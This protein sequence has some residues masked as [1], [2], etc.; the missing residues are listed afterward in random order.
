MNEDV[1]ITI[2]LR[3]DNKAAFLFENFIYKIKKID[4]EIKF[5][6]QPAAYVINNIV[7]SF[8]TREQIGNK[9]VDCI[10]DLDGYKFFD[11]DKNCRCKLCSKPIVP[12]FPSV[13]TGVKN[14]SVTIAQWTEK[15]FFDLI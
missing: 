6:E 4:K 11:I 10:K 15:E 9:G 12:S 2:L 13:N 3:K 14:E 5:A 8:R 1:E 7:Y